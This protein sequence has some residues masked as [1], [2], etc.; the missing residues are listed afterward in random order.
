M[1]FM[2]MFISVIFIL[3]FMK[4]AV[5]SLLSL[6]AHCLHTHRRRTWETELRRE[7]W[8]MFKQMHIKMKTSVFLRDF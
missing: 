5:G 3:Q 8:L 7:T 4:R 1:T 2:G 6:P